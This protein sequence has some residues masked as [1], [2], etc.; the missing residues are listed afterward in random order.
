M[1]KSSKFLLPFISLLSFSIHANEPEPLWEFGLGVAGI[2]FPDYRGSDHQR[3][4]LLPLPTLRYRGEKLRVNREGI[5]GLLYQSER[6]NVDISLDGAVPVKSNENSARAGMPDLDPLLEI[7]PTLDFT[8]KQTS[9]HKLRLRFP[10]RGAFAFDGLQPKDHGWTFHPNLDLDYH[11]QWNLGIALGPLFA[12]QR[13]H[14]Y[15]YSVEPAF[16][17]PTRPSFESSSGYSGTRLILTASRRF[18]GLWVAAF[19]RYDNLNGAVFLDSPLVRKNS[20][21]M[22]G[23]GI[24]W[25]FAESAQLVTIEE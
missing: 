15:Y 7:G 1:L 14:D 11:W 12:N 19:L 3:N 17:T 20:A 2:N 16:A 10:L 5:R 9:D 21:F 23:F 4:Y 8:L 24:S 6:I 18:N 13:Y 22:A 25:F